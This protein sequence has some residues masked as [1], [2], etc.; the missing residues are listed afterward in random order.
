MQQHEKGL[1]NLTQISQLSK[2]TDYHNLLDPS[3]RL[4]KLTG[5][6]SNKKIT[7]LQNNQNLPTYE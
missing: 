3:P 4:R 6:T 5:P 2:H 1:T 7:E